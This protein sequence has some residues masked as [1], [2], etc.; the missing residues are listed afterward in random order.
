MSHILLV[1]APPVDQQLC[2]TLLETGYTLAVAHDCLSARQQAQNQPPQ[3]TILAL[4][5]QMEPAQT[6]CQWLKTRTAAQV[7]VAA[8]T[9]E[10]RSDALQ[11]GADELV[12][13]PLETV[14]VQHRLHTLQA[15][16]NVYTPAPAVKTNPL[17][18]A[19][20]TE[21]L[22][23]VDLLSHDLK[24]PLGI[25]VSSLELVREFQRNNVDANNPDAALEARLSENSLLA[26]H[27][28]LNLIDDMID[29]AKLEVNAYPLTLHPVDLPSL[30]QHVLN[31]N[32]IAI[33]HK[34]ITIETT[35]PDSFPEVNGEAGLINRIVT[36]LLDN[37]L[38]FTTE[39]QQATITFTTQGNAA[40]LQLSDTGRPIL[41]DYAA[42][43]FGRSGQWEARQKGGRSSV[44]LGLPF[45]HAAA[46]L[47][48]GDLT[49]ST[50]LTTRTTTFVLRLP[51]TE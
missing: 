33:Q 12:G 22:G 15:I 23:N 19:E 20:T 34:G 17:L 10:Q 36:A 14:E 29:L 7:L 45:A 8:S 27:R 30:V 25:I 50:D 6:L 32:A 24:S 18:G 48:N 49:A 43:I 16:A 31:T 13:H 46:Q 5:I 1:T 37:T 41:P 4:D 2:A 38:K 47:M 11:C 3:I 39:S 28:L 35:Y 42:A 9:A 40:F 21:I 51:L 44:A 26:S